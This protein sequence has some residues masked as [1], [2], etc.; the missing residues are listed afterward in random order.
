MASPYISTPAQPPAS[1]TSVNYLKY[2]VETLNNEDETQ[3]VFHVARELFA[4][5]TRITVVTDT[6]VEHAVQHAKLI[7][8]SQVSMLCSLKSRVQ[9]LPESLANYSNEKLQQINVEGYSKAWINEKPL[10]ANEGLEEPFE[11]AIRLAEMIVEKAGRDDEIKTLQNELKYR[12]DRAVS[13][14]WISG[15]LRVLQEAGIE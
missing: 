12:L 4:N 9:E 5:L 15:E 6:D 11:G 13:T 7:M 14:G 3:S 2:I 1:A 10:E 8:S